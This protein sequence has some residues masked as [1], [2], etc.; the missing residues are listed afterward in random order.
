[1][2]KSAIFLALVTIVSASMNTVHAD[3]GV[4]LTASVVPV[5]QVPAIA[6]NPSNPT[7][8]ELTGTLK[9]MDESQVQQAGIETA[10]QVR[11]MPNDIALATGKE[12]PPEQ[13]AKFDVLA[14]QLAQDANQPGFKDRVAAALKGAEHGLERAGIDTVKGIGYAGDIVFSVSLVPFYFGADFV[15]SM[16][17]GH[18]VI[19]VGDDNN[20]VGIA[21]YSGGI[22][23]FY[24]VYAGLKAVGYTM[25]G[26]V[27]MSSMGVVVVNELVCLR[28][29][30]DGGTSELDQ[31]C[32][33]NSKILHGIAGGSARF[34]NK[35]GS[36]VH[37]PIAKACDGVVDAAKW[38][39]HFFHHASEVGDLTPCEPKPSPSPSASLSP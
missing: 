1:M 5:T 8:A 7:S 9:G 14:D 29:A 16:I 26:L 28:L 13:K 21:G 27:T 36:I 19:T 22:A 37:K 25:G 10:E 15:S 20:L 31:Y 2:K 18:G 12:L 11:N 3:D 38:I 4:D 34:G 39:R 17:T 35:I 24:Y 30:Q 6:N 33:T 32:D 23:S